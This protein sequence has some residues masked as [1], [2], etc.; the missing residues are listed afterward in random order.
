MPSSTRS[1]QEHTEGISGSG[2]RWQFFQTSSISLP[3]AVLL[4]FLMALLQC[5]LLNP[6]YGD[7]E[8]VCSTLCSAFKCATSLKESIL[9]MYSGNGD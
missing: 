7:E 2:K 8:L 6:T 1:L 3:V 4:S 5:L 9:Y